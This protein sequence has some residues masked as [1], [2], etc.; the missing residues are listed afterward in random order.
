MVIAMKSEIG[1]T[2]VMSGMVCDNF[3][4]DC[5]T[6]AH[7]DSSSFGSSAGIVVSPDNSVDSGTPAR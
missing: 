4:G 5:L 6:R 1:D 7:G 3:D 2:Y